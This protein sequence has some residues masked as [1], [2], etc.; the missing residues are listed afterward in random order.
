MKKSLTTKRM[1]VIVSCVAVALLIL[2]VS[3]FISSYFRMETFLKAIESGDVN[4]VDKMLKD[5][6][7][8]NTTSMRPGRHLVFFET[9][10]RRPITVACKAG[11]FEMVK[12]LIEHGATVDDI[13]Y[14]GW[15]PLMTT[16]F[17]YDVDDREIVR[18]LL[19]AGADPFCGKGSNDS[20]ILETANM[21]PT[22]S[23]TSGKDF[24][25]W[26]DEKIAREITDM[27]LML[28]N[29]EGLDYERNGETLLMHAALGQN[30]YLIKYLIENGCDPNC[31][32]QHGKTAYD[33]ALRTENQEII[34]L[35]ESRS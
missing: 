7:D 26:Y 22:G 12:L 28:L 18:A 30:A 10:A 6:F 5:G 29:D 15:C 17:F 11:S 8:P 1:I 20:V 24:S 9:E 35:F 19:E 33:Y 14:T 21:R 4:T 3:V 34:A 25:E 13:E 32:D 23:S 2:T 27:L 31:V 16:V